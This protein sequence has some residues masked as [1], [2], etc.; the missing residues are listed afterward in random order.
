MSDHVYSF[1]IKKGEVT[2]NSTVSVTDYPSPN[3]LIKKMDAQKSIGL[4]GAVLEVKDES[5]TVVLTGE[6]DENGQLIFTPAH[7]G[8]YTIHEKKAP[9]G[10]SKTDAYIT[11]TIFE[12]GIAT[13]EF[14]IY[15]N[16]K[17]SERRKGFITASY[18]STLSGYGNIKNTGKGFW[19]WLSQMPKTGDKSFNIGIFIF[20]LFVAI[21]SLVIIR[22]RKKRT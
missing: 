9:K 4:L 11:I 21:L 18:H 13:G 10:Y 20:G 2:E 17:H 22:R 1:T 15:N 6:T 12:S 14:I 7:V 5:G 8:K 19:T 3:V 16:Q